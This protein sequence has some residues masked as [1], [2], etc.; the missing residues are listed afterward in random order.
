MISIGLMITAMG[1]I[2][3]Y[4]EKLR[5]Q[6]GLDSELTDNIIVLTIKGSHR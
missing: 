1:T 4:Y 6:F 5:N 2:T 3:Q